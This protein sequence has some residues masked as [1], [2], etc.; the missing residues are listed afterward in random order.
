M[1]IVDQIIEYESGEMESEDLLTMF[2][3]MIENG[4]AWSLQGH[5]GRTAAGLIE[6]GLISRD[7]EV[8][9]EQ[10]GEMTS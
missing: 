8:D 7:G 3:G 2:A 10:F 4:M 9:W 1:D 6:N 5:Y